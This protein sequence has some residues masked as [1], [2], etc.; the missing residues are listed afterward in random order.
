MRVCRTSTLVAGIGLFVGCGAPTESE[1]PDVHAADASGRDA[2]LDAKTYDAAEE[3]NRRAD[4]ID[5]TDAQIVTPDRRGGSDV[6]TSSDAS[7]QPDAGG[8]HDAE[9]PDSPGSSEASSSR[10]V[11]DA[12]DAGV[13][14][15]SVGAD[16]SDAVDASEKIDADA[17]DISNGYDSSDAGV[18][19]DGAASLDTVPDMR[20]ASTKSDAAAGDAARDGTDARRDVAMSCD[21]ASDARAPDVIDQEN[22]AVYLDNWLY[23]GL[24]QDQFMGQ[25]WTVGRAGILSGIDTQIYRYGQP[26]IADRIS[27]RLYR[28]S[29][30]DVCD[31]QEIA[32]TSVPAAALPDI[33]QVVT[34]PPKGAGYFDLSCFAIT[35]APGEIYM[36]MMRPE[37]P[38]SQDFGAISTKVESY[39]RGRLWISTYSPAYPHDLSFVSYV[40]P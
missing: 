4:R 17:A 23:Y 16:T 22:H 39:S 10:D 7:D 5:A 28:C 36:F 14:D 29:A 20:D 40:Q 35:V 1:L 30:L 25:A 15:V 12:S 19:H 18:S 13:I 33:N 2:S 8:R 32:S 31:L 34:A 27:L 9:A 37:S 24:Q 21:A 11:F 26:S 38:P 3:S 6:D